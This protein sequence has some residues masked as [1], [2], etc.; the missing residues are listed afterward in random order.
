MPLMKCTKRGKVI[1][2]V[3]DSPLRVIGRGRK[4]EEDFGV[5]IISCSLICVLFTQ[6]CSVSEKLIRLYT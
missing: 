2:V 1:C 5:Q 6:V 3:R 4:P